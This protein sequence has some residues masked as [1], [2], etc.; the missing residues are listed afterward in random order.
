LGVYSTTLMVV[1]LCHIYCCERLMICDKWY[2]VDN[3]L[4]SPCSIQNNDMVRS[5][6]TPITTPV[7]NERP[8]KNILPKVPKEVIQ[9][10]DETD[11]T[12]PPGS[13]KVFFVAKISNVGLKLQTKEQGVAELQVDGRL[14]VIREVTEH[15]RLPLPLRVQLGVVCG[16]RD[17]I[18]GLRHDGRT[19]S[20]VL[21]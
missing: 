11:L 15:P 10:I 20:H 19:L 4:S 17:I 1:F 7:V 3:C 12:M 18:K 21:R 8:I 6:S 16:T 13:T 5:L 2:V 14:F 9:T